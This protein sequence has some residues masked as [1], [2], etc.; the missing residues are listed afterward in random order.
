MRISTSSADSEE[1]ACTRCGSISRLHTGVCVSCLLREGLDAADEVSRAVFESAIVEVDVPD[2]Q[3]RLGDYEI[4]D[5]IGRGGMGV[6]YLARQRHPQRIVAVKRILDYHGGSHQTLKRFRREADAAASLDHPNI[7]PIYEV[8][9]SEDGLPFFSM[10]F[11][12]GGSLQKVAPAL[13][14]DP[15]R[16]VQLMA[17]VARAVEHAHGQGILHRDLKPGNILLDGHGEPMVSDFGLAKFLDANKDITKSLT[18]F[19]TPGYTAPEQAEGKA[20]NLTP[21]ADVYSLGAILFELLTGRPPFV[22]DNALAVIRRA[23]ETPAP[24]LRSVSHSHDRDLETICARCLERDPKARYQSAGDLAT[25][26]ERWLDGRPI[27]ARPISVPTRLGRWSRRNPKLIVTGAACLLFGI[28][29]MWFFRGERTRVPL[30]PPEKSIAVLPFE[31]LSRD[32]DN[33][34]FADGIQEEILTRLA[35]IADLKVI[36]RISTQRYQ[37]RPRNLAQIA[38]ELGV[39]NIVEGSVQKA[40]DQVR[41]NVQLINAPTD[42]H[43]WAETYDRKLTDVFGVESEVAKGIAESLQAN[44]TGREERALAVKPTNNPEAYDAYLR[45]LSFEARNYVSNVQSY[46]ADLVDKAV[47]FYEH[48]VQLDPNFAIAWARLSGMDALLYFN[49]KDTATAA[50]GDAAKRALENAQKLAPNSAEILLA[51]GYYQYLVLRDYGAA[52]TTFERISKMLPGSSEV[53]YALGRV[54]RREGNWDESIAYFEQALALDPR[55]LEFLMDA[56]QTYGMVRQF[57]AALKLYD[58]VLDI[59][60]DQPDVM[61]TKAGIYQAEGNLQEAAK[62]LSGINEQSPDEVTFIIKVTQLRLERN[63]G[64]AVR[65]QQAR[66]AQFHFQSEYD[67]GF[68]QVLLAL[69][70]H[71]A[72]DT[73]GA[74]YTAE[75]TRKT[76]EQL[77]RD[78]PNNE[79]VT[80]VLSR[81]HAAL[82]EKDSALKEAES[83]ITLLPRGKDAVGG[84]A[85]EENLALIHTI[86]GESGRAISNLTQLLQTPHKGFIYAV[87]PITPALLRVDPLWDPLRSD[88]AFQKLCEEKIDKSIAVLPFENLSGD[89]SNAYFADGIQEEILTRLAKIAD[90]KVISRTSTQRYQSRPRDLGEIAKQLGVANIVEGSVQ[91]AADQV[92][93]NVQLVNAQTDSH[94]WA[95]TYERK[96]T[97]VFGVE[98]E[99]AKRI[100]GSLHAKLSGHEELAL[101]VKAT[102]NPDAYDAY[103]RGLAFQTRSSWQSDDALRNA[104]DSYEQAVQLDPAF[105]PAWARLARAHAWKYSR[106]EG[107]VLRRDAA[108]KA[109][110]KAQKLQPDSPETLLALGYY[111]RFV[112]DDWEAAKTTFRRVGEMLP[113]SSEVPMALGRIA[114]NEGHWDESNSY[115]ERALSMDPRNVELLAHAAWNYDVLRQFPTALKLY[116]RALDI[117]PDDSELVSGKASIYQAQGKLQEAAKLLPQINEQ[118]TSSEAFR[119][120][121][122]QMRLERRFDEAVHLLQTRLAQFRFFSAVEK[123]EYQ[124]ML[125]FH[126]YLAGDRASANFIAKQA[127][128]EIQ[129]QLEG[130]LD[131]DN[132][133][134]THAV[135][136]NND[137][138][139]KSAEHAGTLMPTAKDRVNGPSREEWL[140]L[141]QTIVGENS[142][143]ISILTRLVQTPYLSW[144]YGGPVTPVLLRLDPIWDPLR[145]DPAF[146]KLCEEK[147]P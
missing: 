40:A 62:F 23:A 128:D 55:N 42:S 97:D 67:K 141:I 78:Q 101:A 27:I 121:I 140:A 17:K 6:I 94:L 54:A 138:A 46:S 49:R 96:L 66:L 43:L 137:L 133:A 100:A 124:A 74:Q 57:P 76:L 39:A 29:T 132:L 34:Y 13:R 147:Q 50:R 20:A 139:I 142:P 41:V 18:T 91:K 113:S 105:A 93:V 7:L 56:A 31:N 89:P 129:S 120:K 95:E 144:L 8:S 77:Y 19:G 22:G 64:E 12:T 51:L 33:A 81:A 112:L 115:F 58:R 87:T 98:S 68:D 36:S 16:C 53:P 111:Q 106:A 143:A 86:V 92:R 2:K 71:L 44:L 21:A 10:K 52:K 11:A 59:T 15:R 1:V 83:A 104:I 90:L 88:P 79:N 135:M 103:L 45:G 134:L 4:L 125:S 116:D 73:A 119:V 126:L 127:R 107:T 145:A 14:A 28:A 130:S 9:E 63:Y 38:K 5:E 70:Q 85:M 136:G 84:P 75:R 146:Q 60:P 65:L 122:T 35:G 108:T 82:G 3:W 123:S 117:V 30:A 48:A 26:L 37:S 32:P 102:N 24:K 114:R 99:I 109:L 61:A 47:S 69:T 80:A 72:G 25:D 131:W 110:N 118:T